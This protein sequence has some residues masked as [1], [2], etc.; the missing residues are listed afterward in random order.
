MKKYLLHILSIL[1]ALS[2]SSCRDDVFDNLFDNG[3]DDITIEIDFMPVS[4][5][6]LTT[7]G[8]VSSTPGDDMSNIKDICLVIYN[9]YDE[10]VDA[11]DITSLHYEESSED[12]TAD[13]TSNGL[14]TTETSSIRRS[15]HLQ[16]PTGKHYV[17]AVANLGEYTKAGVITKSTKS[18]LD[19]M[20][21]SSV[22]RNNFR[23][24]RRTW[25]YNNMN[26]NS[27][28]TGICTLGSLPGGSVYTGMEESAIYVRPGITLHCWLRRLA[29]KVTVDFDATNLNASTTIYLKE[30]RV[31]DI[32][33]DC[34]LVEKNCA[35]PYVGTSGGLMDNNKSVSAI[36]LC[37]DSYA[38]KEDGEDEHANWPFLTSGYP[39]LKDLVAGFNL[40]GSNIPQSVKNQKNLLLSIG[41]SNS[42]P[43]LFFYE[44]MQGKDKNKPKDPDADRDGKIDSPDSYLSTDP[45]YKD[46][47]PGG[48]YVEV[49][50]YYHSLEKGNEG[51]GNIIYRFMLG[52]DVIDDYDAERN[53]HFKL[54]MC[55]MGYANDVDW[56]IEY[57]RDKPPYSIPE[58]Y[59]ISY[60]YNE[61]M[62]FPITVSGTLKDGVITA[63][64]VRN[65][66]MPSIMWED[67]HPANF[68]N[69]A[70][71]YTP[72]TNA[73]VTYPSGDT[74]KVSLGFLSLRKPQNDVLGANKDAGT[75]AG[76]SHPYLW[77]IWNGGA[78]DKGERSRNTNVEDKTLYDY[79]TIPQ[80]MYDSK[81]NNK[82]CLGFRIY[83]FPQKDLDAVGTG[84]VTYN[85]SVRPEYADTLDGGYRVHTIKSNSSIYPRQS[86]YYI[87]MYTRERNLCTKTGYTGENP[88][89]NFQRRAA[90]RIK[91]TVTD[92]HGVDHVCDKT[93]PIIQVAKIGNPMGVWRDWNRANSFNVQLKYLDEDGFNF[94]DLTS[95]EGGWSAEVETGADWILLNGSRKK[96]TGGKD[97]KIAF[98]IRPIGILS[99]N[100]QVRC[101]IVTVKY[102]NYACVHK[103]FVRQGYAPL[104]LTSGGT[105]YHTG[106]L[107]T[108]T[109]EASNPCDEGSMFRAGNLDDPID[110]INNVND[111]TPWV[112]VKP[113]MFI[114]HANTQLK[115]AGTSNK[116]T[117]ANIA[118]KHTAEGVFTWPSFT[119]NGKTAQIMSIADIV[120]MRDDNNSNTG[121]TRYQYGVLYSDAASGT[122]NTLDEAYHY[123]QADGNTH[124]YGMR[125]CFVYNNKDG[126]QIFFPIGSSGYGVRKAQRTTE[127]PI[128]NDIG[129]RSKAVE[130]GT[131]VVRYAA[132]R[133]TYSNAP[134]N[135]P[136]LWDIFRADGAN[137]WADKPASDPSKG[138]GR[139]SLDLNYRTFD[140]NTLGTEL[141]MG[142]KTNANYGSD[143]C[144]IRLVD[145]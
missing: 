51:E 64:I 8:D 65:D 86:T 126:R 87:P 73:A 144:F 13:D 130:V 38:T 96:I 46:K 140:F 84:D 117:W 49:V 85:E 31:K 90:V 102:H 133:I 44:N 55:F 20:K 22:S 40:P 97:D 68:A 66:W 30:I 69:G 89:N 137:Y 27:E 19:E 118:S 9:E 41:H 25:D 139:T 34:P 71:T 135:M 112:Q 132:G 2:V 92:R 62:E 24:M 81:Y 95:H 98:S 131:G 103:I 18:A 100:N 108:K 29:S 60:G 107:V 76:Q 63:E 74:K 17:Y 70:G 88:Y 67:R 47:M 57:D 32:P 26:N 129:W 56:H 28:M 79:N 105:A 33:Y 45:D 42:A 43:S 141:F 72:Y 39:T 80:Y 54:T 3:R 1:F 125:G 114:D 5:A 91:F 94:K 14:S 52:K 142:M 58:E 109:S 106:N 101:G 12:R 111:Q 110:A 124:S 36:R 99:N 48:T 136:L 50:A 78:L 83:K 75:A 93:I 127:S 138:A 11:I 6:S 104:Q 134:A 4:S 122:G 115:I 119:I 123:K 10:F 143:A 145:R 21:L 23:K 16:L 15:Y 120:S 53:Y 121:M 37:S 77:T 35:T 82:R 59:Y 128:P 61:S 7:R 116:K 113:N